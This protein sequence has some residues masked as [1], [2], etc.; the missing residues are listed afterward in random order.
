MCAVLCVKI[1]INGLEL[2]TLVCLLQNFKI[3][4]Y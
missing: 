4:G 3:C 2:T 1:K